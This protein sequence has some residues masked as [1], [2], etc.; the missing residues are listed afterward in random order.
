MIKTIF[1][2]MVGAILIAGLAGCSDGTTA[3]SSAS[4][5][6]ETVYI[7]EYTD[8]VSVQECGGYPK[9]EVLKEVKS[10]YFDDSGYLVRYVVSHLL[11]H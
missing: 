3:S 4:V 1:K 8:Y 5:S 7:P 11:G 10:Y 9:Y 6:E 2:I